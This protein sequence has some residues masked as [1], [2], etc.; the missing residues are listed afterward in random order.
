MLNALTSF[1]F[2]AAIMVFIF[3]L[4]LFSQYQLGAAGVSFFFVLSGFILAYNYHNHFFTIDKARLRKFY[5]AR[6]AKIYP[7][8]VLTF[9]IAFPLVIL[10]FNPDGLYF[11][12]LA[13]MS[14]VNLS[15]LQ[16]FVPNQGTY[17]NFNG[18]SWTLSVEMFFYITFPFLFMGIS[19]NE[20]KYECI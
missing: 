19:E 17:F 20:G 15:L 16:S 11:I 10:Y 7:I 9:L 2:I 6:F 8:H 14:I 12:K 4:G 1:R 5:I 13:F 3:H 18:V